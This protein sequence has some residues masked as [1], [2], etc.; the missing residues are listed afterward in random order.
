[1]ERLRGQTENKQ[2]Q[3]DNIPFFKSDQT[4]SG[5][6]SR[7]TSSQS[8]NARDM[9]KKKDDYAVSEHKDSSDLNEGKYICAPPKTHDWCTVADLGA[10]DMDLDLDMAL[11][12]DER[13]S[14]GLART[15][16]RAEDD[17]REVGE[18]EDERKEPQEAEGEEAAELVDNEEDN[19]LN[20]DQSWNWRSKEIPDETV[21]L[22]ERKEHA[23]A[24]YKE[25]VADRLLAAWTNVKPVT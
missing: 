6:K 17:G 4:L 1:M 2:E 3:T 13:G 21:E 23:N 14:E 7:S 8:N 9:G 10:P 25:S 11:Y 20:F 22:K 24:R 15:S 5:L 12:V 18:G 19:L 16:E